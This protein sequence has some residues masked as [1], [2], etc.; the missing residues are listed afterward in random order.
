[1]IP[2]ATVLFWGLASFSICMYLNCLGVTSLKIS[3]KGDCRMDQVKRNNPP[4]YESE[5]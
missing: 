4:K 3:L 1:M 5:D 2:D